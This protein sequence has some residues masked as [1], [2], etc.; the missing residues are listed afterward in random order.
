MGKHCCF[1]LRMETTASEEIP[2]IM[3]ELPPMDWELIHYIAQLTDAERIERAMKLAEA[4][5]EKVGN[6]TYSKRS[7]NR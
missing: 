6:G 5:R 1:E 2:K 3:N 4:E 7:C